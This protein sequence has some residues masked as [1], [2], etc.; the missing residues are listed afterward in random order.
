M[1]ERWEAPSPQGVR[2]G[3]F[4]DEKTCC[5]PH[6]HPGIL[7]LG[8][9]PRGRQRP[10]VRDRAGLRAA[11]PAPREAAGAAGAE[12]VTRRDQ[13]SPSAPD[14]RR[15]RVQPP[16]PGPSVAEPA[17]TG[18]RAHLVPACGP[19]G[20]GRPRPA[21]W[22]A[23]WVAAARRPPP[24]PGAQP[25][26]VQPEPLGAGR[27]GGA[28]AGLSHAGGVAGACGADRVIRPE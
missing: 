20:M 28:P 27:A 18:P 9:A 3:G 1:R 10:G 21:R 19:Q 4:S 22:E 26:S 14:S 5:P 11:E 12:A 13:G 6:T 15:A 8:S 23:P 24:Q 25:G 2:T 17:G 7:R 16:P